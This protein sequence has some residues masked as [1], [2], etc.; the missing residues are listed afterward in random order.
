MRYQ[1]FIETRSGW[2]SMCDACP[3]VDVAIEWARHYLWWL[4]LAAKTYDLTSP[5][6]QAWRDATEQTEY[7]VAVLT[8]TTDDTWPAYMKTLPK[9]ACVG[10]AGFTKVVQD[11]KWHWI[12]G[13]LT[14]REES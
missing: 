9:T 6:R 10:T 3:S 8:T 2:L 12:W 4:E 11:G 13:W 14:D 5:A 1:S 7:T